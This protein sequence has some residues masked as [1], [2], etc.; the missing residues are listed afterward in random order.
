[1]QSIFNA[2]MT[3]DRLPKGLGV[4]R[5]AHD[6]IATFSGDLITNF[7]L[8]FDY[9]NATQPGPRLYPSIDD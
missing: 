7:A 2:P 1:M 4:A 8:R 9:A 5:K 6:G 3:P